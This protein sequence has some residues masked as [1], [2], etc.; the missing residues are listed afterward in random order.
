M[1]SDCKNCEGQGQEKILMKRI[2]R[3][4]GHN[5]VVYELPMTEEQAAFFLR[6]AEFKVHTDPRITF[7]DRF[8]EVIAK[9]KENWKI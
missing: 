8:I 5:G 4:V 1:C 3:V 9:W 2:V 6:M 7:H